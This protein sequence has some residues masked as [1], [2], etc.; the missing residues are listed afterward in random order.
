MPALARFGVLSEVMSCPSSRMLPPLSGRTPMTPLSRVVLPMPLRPM[1]Q[2]RLPSG[3]VNE[4]PN[5]TSV[6]P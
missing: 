2:V 6:R 4:T 1:R 3:T 5:T